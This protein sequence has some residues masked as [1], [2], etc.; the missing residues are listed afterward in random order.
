MARARWGAVQKAVFADTCTP[1]VLR[2][3]VPG[4]GDILDGAAHLRAM[5]EEIG[6]LGKYQKAS[7]FTQDRSQQRVAK[8][9][10]N[11]MLL[12]DN[13]HEAACTCSRSLWGTNGHKSW[14]FDWLAGPGA[15]F[16]T[17]GKVTL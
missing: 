2:E 17:R 7:G 4:M 15:A 13:L 8:I 14:F 10:T 1:E 12:L 11:I 6:V 3:N 5:H 9:D 16:D